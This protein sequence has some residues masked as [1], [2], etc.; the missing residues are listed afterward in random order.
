MIGEFKITFQAARI[1]RGYSV[2]EVAE[3]T[4]R[5]PD[6]IRKYEIDSSN[7]PHDLMIRL[8]EMYQVPHRLIFFGKESEFHGFYR[9]KSSA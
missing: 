1:N 6:T 7:I 5:H 4:G 2:K 3:L 8:L 9:T